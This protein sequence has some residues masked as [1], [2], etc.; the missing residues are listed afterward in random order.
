M[1]GPGRAG[2]D[3]AGAVVD[4]ARRWL[5]TP[6]MHAASLRGVGC[7]CLGLVRGIWRALYGDEPEEA[8]PYSADWAE[9]TGRERLLEAAQRH[10]RAA[11]DGAIRAGD[12][13]VLRWRDGS[14]AKHLGIATGPDTMIHAHDGACVA[15][16]GFGVWRTRIAGIFRFPALPARDGWGGEGP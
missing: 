7:D 1:S 14:P 4:E 13:L 8:G 9:A 12:L 6:Y 10:L 16:V 11:Q 5:G 15:E 3:P 2:R